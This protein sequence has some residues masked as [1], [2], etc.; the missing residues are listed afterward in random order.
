MYQD[1]AK[2]KVEMNFIS[3][4]SQKSFHCRKNRVN[5]SM[6]L[7]CQPHRVISRQMAHFE[8][9]TSGLWNSYSLHLFM[10]INFPKEMFC[11]ILYLNMWEK[12]IQNQLW[13]HRNQTWFSFLFFMI[14]LA[15]HYLKLPTFSVNLLFGTRISCKIPKQTATHV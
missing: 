13:N 7:F 2:D 14:A 8:M 9:Q 1:T 11:F 3:K 12:I 6:L 10:K 15:K 5:T 4:N